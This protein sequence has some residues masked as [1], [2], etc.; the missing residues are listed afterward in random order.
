MALGT[1]INYTPAGGGGTGGGGQRLSRSSN[2]M[3]PGAGL[4]YTGQ[5]QYTPPA[6]VHPM[7]PPP[8]R[9]HPEITNIGSVLT[10]PP[11]TYGTPTIDGQLNTGQIISDTIART[12]A[13]PTLSPEQQAMQQWLQA[14]I[15]Q[16]NATYNLTHANLQNQ[17]ATGQAYA[18][19]L[20]G[21][22][23]SQ[24]GITN[25]RN[26]LDVWRA[27]QV[28]DI[29]NR[30]LA[31]QRGTANSTWAELQRNNAADV[32]FNRNTLAAAIRDASFQA[33]QAGRHA[34]Y[35]ATGAGAGS[36]IG[37]RLDQ[38]DILTQR[39]NTADNA[40]LS[41][42]KT[43]EQLRHQLATGQ[44]S[45]TDALNQIAAAQATG[46]LNL[47]YAT[48]GGALNQ[49]QAALTRDSAINGANINQQQLAQTLLGQLVNAG[50]NANSNNNN[51]WAQF[52]MW[53]A[54]NGGG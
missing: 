53:L 9:Q 46:N 21:N 20:T 19:Y 45:Y 40:R 5:Q 22:A 49:Q 36:S 37:H 16:N 39:N 1:P 51:L 14:A 11:P 50:A 17:L 6:G 23:N 33:D 42:A 32:G 26:N 10:A 38:R 18:N 52:Q 2:G 29:L 34:L 41:S 31:G 30:Q 47:D 43:A 27:Q 4:T 25:G 48:K 13:S 24:Y 8:P 3:D 7:G 44:I 28:S 15:G 54:Q 35:Q 12:N